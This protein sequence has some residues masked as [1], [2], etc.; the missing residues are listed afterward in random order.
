MGFVVDHVVLGF[1]WLFGFGAMLVGE[2]FILGKTLSRVSNRASRFVVL[3]ALG[4]PFGML[5]G[6][7][8]VWLL[9]DNGMKWTEALFLA[10]PGALLCAFLFTFWSPLSQDSSSR[11]GSF[12]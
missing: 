11:H 1:I 4:V 9:G 2:A 3:F 7:S 10:L 6:Y 8:K 5:Y 12:E